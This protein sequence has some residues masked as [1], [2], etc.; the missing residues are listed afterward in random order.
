MAISMCADAANE[1]TANSRFA[2]PVLYSSPAQ[3]EIDVFLYNITGFYALEPARHAEVSAALGVATMH[4]SHH[5]RALE[6]ARRH[7][8][9]EIT[10]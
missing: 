3:A 9:I 10:P 7:V 6:G 4:F 1:S 2:N 8:T 5:L